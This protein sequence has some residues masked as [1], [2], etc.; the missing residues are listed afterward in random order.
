[1]KTKRLGSSDLELTVIGLGTWAIGGSWQFGWGEQDERDSIDT[2][3]RALEVGINWIDTAPIYGCGDSEKVIGKALGD[4][5]RCEKPLIATK[6][7]LVWNQKREKINCLDAESIMNEC[8]QSLRRL[9]IETIDLYQMHWPVPD[10]RIEEAF[11]A[12]DKC[13]K[14]GKVRF[15][16]VCNANIEQ[17]ERLGQVAQLSSLQPPYSLLDRRSEELFPYCGNNEIGV[18]CYSPMQKGLLT[19][20]VTHEF[21]ESLD[22]DDHRRGDPDFNE[23]KLSTHTKFVDEL[24][25]I[26]RRHGRTV[27]QLAIAW[28][29]HRPE[30]TAAIVGARRPG[31]IEE[32]AKAA[33]FV[34]S[35]DDLKEIEEL[36]EKYYG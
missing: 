11:E 26:A 18:V 19:G 36:W 23:P 10:G 33:E 14:Q 16:A 24:T 2:I 22:E 12:M 13:R 29:L 7:G 28:T 20:K 32:T 35:A 25:E 9:R 1:M 4:I 30:V 27:A 31:Q 5:G 8:E 34:L 21:V 6:C 3:R 17:M 15:I